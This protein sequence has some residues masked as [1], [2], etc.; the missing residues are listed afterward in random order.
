MSY[1]AFSRSCAAAALLL[2]GCAASGPPAGISPSDPGYLAL[3][4]GDYEAAKV[5]FTAELA[6]HPNNPYI[7][8]DLALAQQKTGHMD[9]AEPLYRAVLVTGRGVYPSAITTDTAA[10]MSLDQIACENLRAGL[11]NPKAC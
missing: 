11:G 7:Q 8:L 6:S 5:A 2:A 9:L 10:G 1:R 4:R 3:E